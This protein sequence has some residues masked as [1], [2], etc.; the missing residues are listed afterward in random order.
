[1]FKGDYNELELNCCLSNFVVSYI[2]MIQFNFKFFE[3]M[4]DVEHIQEGR[5]INANVK[6]RY[7][8]SH[9]NLN[10]YFEVKRAPSL[11]QWSYLLFCICLICD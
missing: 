2:L 6:T 4:H 7:T 1:M 9:M 8:I 5:I 10:L 3:S 11:S